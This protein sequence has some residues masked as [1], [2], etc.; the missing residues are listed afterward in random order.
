MATSN[1]YGV[2]DF[3]SEYGLHETVMPA[4]LV[5][6][7][8]S[9]AIYFGVIGSIEP[10]VFVETIPA[11]TAENAMLVFLGTLAVTALSSETRDWDYYHD[12]EQGYL[13]FVGVG[14][15]LH[16][17]SNWFQSWTSGFGAGYTL[18]MFVLVTIATIVIAR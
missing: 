7:V 1:R 14:T 15:L 13:I 11:L 6:S 5:L 9:S 17:F 16:E 3:V 10:L 4:M 12:V 18:G 2:G 8:V